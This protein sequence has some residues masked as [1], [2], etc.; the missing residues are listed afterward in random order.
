MEGGYQ[1][2]LTDVWSPFSLRL[3]IID[4]VLEVLLDFQIQ[5]GKFSSTTSYEVIQICV[6]GLVQSTKQTRITDF[7]PQGKIK[8]NVKLHT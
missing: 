1:Q 6:Q 3:L 4:Q 8:L 2:N 7:S 5:N